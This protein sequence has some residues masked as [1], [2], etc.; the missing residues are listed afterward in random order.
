MDE[1]YIFGNVSKRGCY[2]ESNVSRYEVVGTETK[3]KMGMREGGRESGGGRKP[4][5]VKENFFFFF[6]F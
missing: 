3:R 2:K 6:F 4:G 5:S 1:I